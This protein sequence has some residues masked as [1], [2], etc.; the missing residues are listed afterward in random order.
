M[1][2]KGRQM[3]GM[4]VYPLAEVARYTGVHVS[5]LRYWFLP[6][7]RGK[8]PIFKSQ[9]DR[10]ENDF[11]V[12]FVNLIEAHVAA[13]FKSKGLTVH[14]IRRVHDILKDQW[15]IPHPFASQ[16]LRIDPDAKQLILNRAEDASLVD[17]IKNQLV[18]ETARPY[19]ET[20]DYNQTTR[21]AERWRIAEGVVI[22]PKVSFGKPVVENAGIST[23]ILA[24][25]YKANG[26][27][28]KL[29]A[30]LFEITEHGVMDAYR[31]EHGV[32]RRV[33]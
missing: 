9:W 23:L 25:Q 33:A 14:H 24:R 26:G 12:S 29:I 8:P 21:L 28:A 19:L 7:E 31:F 2:A 15:D 4:G 6:H 16:D 18:L 22:N 20:I 30:K 11:A 10:V 3:L 13:H 27:N 17:V 32:T 5:T 1:R